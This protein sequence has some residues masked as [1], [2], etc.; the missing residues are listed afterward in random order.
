MNHL[1]E[2]TIEL[3]ILNAPELNEQRAEIEAHLTS[4]EGCREMHDDMAK[5]YSGVKA[6]LSVGTASEPAK[7]EV[8]PAVYSRYLA[9]S[10]Q[11]LPAIQRAAIAVPWRIAKWMVH[12]PYMASS[13]MVMSF[14]VFAGLVMFLLQPKAQKPKDMNPVHAVYKGE[15]MIVE[16]R[17]G[18]PLDTIEVGR[19]TVETA[20]KSEELKL[21]KFFDVDNDGRNEIIWGIMPESAPI[22]P[23]I[24]YCKSIRLQKILWSRTLQ[25]KLDFPQ[26]SVNEDFVCLNILVG[27][28]DK[29]GIPQVYILAH[30][31]YFPSLVI[32]L[33][34]VHGVDI[35]HYVHIGGINYITSIDLHSDGITELVLSGMSNYLNQ[36]VCVVLDP[37]FVSGHSPLGGKYLL[38]DHEP[39]K[40]MAYLGFPKSILGLQF[41]GVMGNNEAGTLQTNVNG[42]RITIDINE[43]VPGEENRVT[44]YLTLDHN[45]KVVDANTSSIYDEIGRKMLSH[46]EISIKPDPLYLKNVYSKTIQYWDGDTWQNHPVQNKYYLEA[47]E[48]LTIAQRK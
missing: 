31:S 37:R 35:S 43:K 27:D 1:D 22:N 26:N 2:T 25:Y 38:N 44:F 28:Y 48:K 41:G 47:V 42:K 39:A 11:D 16:N 45:F 17:F 15:V 14:V 12:H 9:K 23:S 5:F 6:D 29:S 8:L 33:D 46:G 7:V 3:Y 18:E 40:E 21:V 13:G 10:Y 34:A 36:A 19:T 32:K 4:C 20:L 30:D 24:I